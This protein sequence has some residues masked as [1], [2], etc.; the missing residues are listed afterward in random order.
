MIE[1]V[2]LSY[3]WQEVLILLL[4]AVILIGITTKKFKNRLE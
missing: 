1:G 3:V 2:P 4:M